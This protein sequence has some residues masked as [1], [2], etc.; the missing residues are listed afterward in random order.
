MP[1][2]IRNSHNSPL[3]FLGGQ[4]IYSAHVPWE[5]DILCIGCRRARA[6]LWQCQFYCTRRARD[7]LGRQAGQDAS[8]VLVRVVL[9]DG[10]RLELHVL[11]W[12]WNGHNVP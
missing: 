5:H 11:G 6:L 2:L 10:L 8:V 3:I 9:C 1:D 7:R 4:L 12:P